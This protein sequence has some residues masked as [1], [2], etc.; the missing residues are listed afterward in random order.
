M[1]TIQ[2]R[3]LKKNTR[4]SEWC[5]QNKYSLQFCQCTR[6]QYTDIPEKFEEKYLIM[7]DF[8]FPSSEM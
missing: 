7:V 5:W 2:R 8:I 3:C 4:D 6:K 1:F